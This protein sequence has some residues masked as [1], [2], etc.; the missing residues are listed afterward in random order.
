MYQSPGAL[1][2]ITVD[3]YFKGHQYLNGSRWSSD[4]SRIGRPGDVLDIDFD[5]KMKLVLIGITD[6]DFFRFR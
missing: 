5:F 1:I 3:K 2:F 6:P 4:L